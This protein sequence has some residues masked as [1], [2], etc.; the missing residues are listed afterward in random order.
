MI[1]GNGLIR[2]APNASHTVGEEVEVL[3]LDR[4]FEMKEAMQ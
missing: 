1:Q 3:L 4:R 2:L